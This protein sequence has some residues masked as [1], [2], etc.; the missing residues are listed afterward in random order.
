MA[1]AGAGPVAQ[2]IGSAL[3]GSAITVEF[4]ASR[5]LEHARAAADFIGGVK[6]LRYRDIPSHASHVLIAV[7][8]RALAPVAAE[9]ASTGGL[10]VALHTC[11]SYGPEVLAPLAEAG[12]ACGAIHP[13]QT[14]REGAGGAAALRGAAF[15]VSGDA[16]ALDWAE[17]IAAVL[18]GQVLRIDSGA[19]RIY[20][21]AAVM[22]SNSIAALLHSAEQL[23]VRAGV[24]R[25]VALRSL[26]PLARTSL[27]N[28]LQ[29]GAVEALTG[30]VVRG[31]A[32]TV[33]GHLQALQGA[34]ESITGLYRAAALHALRMARERG[35]GEQEAA[36]VR[37][38]LRER[39]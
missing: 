11:G 15:A 17:E 1:I 36:E 33:A 37:R 22:A 31:D 35:L 24:P 19:R 18:G 38:A 20:H 3:R 39:R 5:S 26:A 21:A 32:A 28:V 25:E 34:D 23:M 10:Q 12:V 6:A 8:D 9:L 7:S 27:E 29:Y 13:L 2:A 30:P 4:L 16:A 14:I